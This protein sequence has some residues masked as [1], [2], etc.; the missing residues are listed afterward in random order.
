MLMVRFFWIS[1]TP[2]ALAKLIAATKGREIDASE[3]A[4]ALDD[5]RFEIT[6]LLERTGMHDV[7]LAKDTARGEDVVVKILHGFMADDPD[8]VREFK[9]VVSLSFDGTPTLIASGNLAQDGSGGTAAPYVV[10]EYAKGVDLGQLL[11]EH[12]ALDQQV[13]MEVAFAGPLKIQQR[14]GTTDAA[15]LADGLA[16]VRD[17]V[18]SVD[19]VVVPLQV[20]QDDRVADLVSDLV[21]AGVLVV[22]QGGDRPADL[23]GEV[24]ADAGSGSL[25]ALATPRPDEDAGPLVHPAA[26][27][28]MAARVRA[29]FT[30]KPLGRRGSAS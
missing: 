11:R 13:A 27:P 25:T 30:G 26:G 29:L 16:H 17:R 5:A 21:E 19:I 1:R 3:P 6:G 7:W 20:P 2:A 22:A 14:L 15:A 10:L 8:L 12:G 28:R 18:P 23:V 24:A 9:S 4:P